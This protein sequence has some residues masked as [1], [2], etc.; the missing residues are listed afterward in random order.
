M[1][2]SFDLSKAVAIVTGGAGMLGSEYVATLRA[3]GA[4]VAAID[5]RRPDSPQEHVLY[6]ECDITSGSS[7]RVAF[8]H[9]ES[10]LGTPTVLVNNAGRDI[11]PDAPVTE[12]GPFEDYPEE[13]WDAVIDSHLKGA[14]LVS[15]EFIR[16]NR[17]SGLGG[18][19]INVSSTYGVVSPD[20]SLYEY[21][22]KAGD[23]FFKPVSYSVAKSGMLNF[24]RWLAEYAGPL[25][26]RV[27]TLVPGGVENSQ[28]ETFLAEYAKRTML[29]R[30]AEKHEY[31][32]AVL[33]L[34][35]DASSYMTGST[36][37]VDG[38]WTAK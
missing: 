18:S 1:S 7:L 32:G 33:F 29:G 27:N 25:K 24:T 8:D 11:R 4:K 38:G 35:S 16:R 15:K 19:I 30:L 31:N 34:A 3:A 21:R 14:F 12:N 22:R 23:A 6:I 28:D 5:I 17:A 13:A 10:S 26:I 2:P 36:L 20:Q 37:I 9:I